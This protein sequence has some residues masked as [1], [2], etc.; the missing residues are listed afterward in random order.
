M[1]RAYSNSARLT[2]QAME[3]IE[4]VETEVIELTIPYDKQ[5]QLE[6][7]LKQNERAK[8][9]A[10]EFSSELKY[11]ISIPKEYKSELLASLKI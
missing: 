7:D 9:I 8:I 2:L 11:T 1:V 10:R 6:Y 3:L 5:R 4:Y